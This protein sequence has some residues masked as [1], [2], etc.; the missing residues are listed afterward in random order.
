GTK[1]ATPRGHYVK[2]NEDEEAPGVQRGIQTSYRGHSVKT[3]EDEQAPD[4]Q[5]RDDRDADHEHSTLCGILSFAFSEPGGLGS[6]TVLIP[7]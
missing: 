3:N 5:R 2:T 1:A 4:M 7:K 6:L